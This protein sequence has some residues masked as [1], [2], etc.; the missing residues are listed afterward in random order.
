MRQKV[1]VTL[2]VMVFVALMPIPAVVFNGNRKQGVDVE[3]NINAVTTRALT[4]MIEF[5]ADEGMNGALR[6]GN[7]RIP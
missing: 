6:L 5:A 4:A 7:R 1:L 2:G 3:G